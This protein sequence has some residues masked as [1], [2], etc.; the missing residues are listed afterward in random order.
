MNPEQLIVPAERGCD[1]EGGL[2]TVDS[3]VSIAFGTIYVDKKMLRPTG[4]KLLA[5][6]WEE[7]DH[8]KRGF[9]RSRL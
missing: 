2:V 3:F 6:L 4:Q 5:I 1:R 7:N 9:L 8:L